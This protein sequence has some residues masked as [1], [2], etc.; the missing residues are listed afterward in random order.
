[1]RA[2]SRSRF[3]QFRGAFATET[4]PLVDNA[5]TERMRLAKEEVRAPAAR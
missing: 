1:M 5:V 4:H 3:L 2:S